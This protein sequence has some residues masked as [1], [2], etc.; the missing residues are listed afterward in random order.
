[1]KGAQAGLQPQ[2]YYAYTTQKSCNGSTDPA[3]FGR[4]FAQTPAP[5]SPLAFRQPAT[6]NIYQSCTTV[7]DVAGLAH[8]A[9]VHALSAS[10]L[11]L[12]VSGR[13]PCQAGVNG[14]VVTNQDTAPGTI[15]PTDAVVNLVETAVNCP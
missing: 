1:V 15:V 11:Q 4:V 7:P 12:V 2:G 10:N 5:G 14:S 8:S 9:A 3:N 13:V 6:A